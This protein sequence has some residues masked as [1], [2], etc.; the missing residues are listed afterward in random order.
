MRLS[1]NA[2]LRKK[3]TNTEKENLK[4][5]LGA[6]LGRLLFFLRKAEDERCKKKLVVFVGWRKITN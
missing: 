5:T 1:K 3:Q 6:V 2:E 4:K